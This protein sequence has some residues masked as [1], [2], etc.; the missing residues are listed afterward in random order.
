MHNWESLTKQANKAYSSHDF[1]N[2]VV[3]NHQALNILTTSFNEYFKLDIES[4]IS[5]AAVSFLNLA[6][7]YTA[8]DN[9]V[10]AHNQ[11][12]SAINFLQAVLSHADIDNQH[13][14]LVMHSITRIRCEWEMFNEHQAKQ[15]VSQGST[16]FL[17]KSTFTPFSDKTS[18]T[19]QITHH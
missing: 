9:P 12:E 11:Y 17:N 8:L 15:L 19:K 6:E 10:L 5:A 7:S 14:C 16:P 18:Y 1:E 2:A 13:Y 4:Y 3:L